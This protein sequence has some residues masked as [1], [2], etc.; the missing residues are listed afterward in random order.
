MKNLTLKE[1]AI[2]MI[3]AIDS[4]NYLLKSHHRRVAVISYY[5]AIELE[6]NEEEL[7]KLVI[8]VGLHDIGAL[9]VSER[10]LLIQED[11]D[12]PKPHCIIGYKML[13]GFEV[14]KDIAQIIKHHHIYLKDMQNM[15]KDEVPFQSFIIHLADRVDILLL[16]DTNVDTQKEYVLSHIEKKVGTIFHPEVFEAF[17]KVAKLDN[18]WSDIENMSID[19]LF[20]KMDFVI[21]YEMDYDDILEFALM[22]SRIVDFRSRFTASHSYAVAQLAFLI[23]TLL[24]HDTIYCKKLKIAGYLHDIGKIGIDPAIIEKNGKL[25]SKEFKTIQL[26]PYYREQ[27]LHELQKTPWFLD[28]VSWAA[29]H[30]EKNDGKG[31]PYHLEKDTLD[32]GTKI[33]AFADV[34][35]ALTENRPYIEGMDIQKAFEIIKND[36]APKISSS[37]FE[38]IEIFKKEINELV[39]EC[40]TYSSLEYKNAINE[41]NS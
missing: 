35:T 26:H 25:T 33:L 17:L 19:V 5:I 20:R 30:H 14:F 28:I 36:L 34:I 3:K 24:G 31:Y 11:V 8:A 40:N 29:K 18:F 27:I 23:G 41:A 15:P 22:I 10:D 12:N 7:L 32:E 1:L 38:K 16:K 13:A 37:M 9:S 6:L 4:F 2:P 21:D 39:Q